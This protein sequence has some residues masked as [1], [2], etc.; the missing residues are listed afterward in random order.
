MGGSCSERAVTFTFP[1]VG[2]AGCIRMGGKVLLGKRIGAHA[3]GTWAF[4]GGHLEYGEDPV[5]CI[6]REIMEETGLTVEKISFWC[7]TNDLYPVEGRHY[8]TLVFFAEYEGGEPQN[9]EPHKCEKWGWFDWD[10]L[11]QPLMSPIQR[12]VT[13][14]RHPF[15]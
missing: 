8:I 13:D 3:G 4:P 6:R 12:M 10:S 11:P 1:R 7:Y 2:T 15:R 5:E 14:G 9:L